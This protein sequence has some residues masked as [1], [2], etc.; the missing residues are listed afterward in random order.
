MISKFEGNQS[1]KRLVVTGCRLVL[2]PAR[3]QGNQTMTDQNLARTGN[4]N[5][6]ANGCSPVQ[7]PV[8]ASPC[9]R[10]L[11]HYFA[12]GSTDGNVTQRMSAS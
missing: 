3:T 9:N 8:F 7:L 2:A 10:T 11:E 5:S 12:V 4:H 6:V 1:S